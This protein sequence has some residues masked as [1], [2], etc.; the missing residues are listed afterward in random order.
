MT[1]NSAVSLFICVTAMMLMVSGCIMM[2]KQ[3][4]GR[5]QR[6]MDYVKEHGMALTNEA[7]ND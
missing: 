7:T 4:A 3:W 5:A 2:C 1:T 6:Q